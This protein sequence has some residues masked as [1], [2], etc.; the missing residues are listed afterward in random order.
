VI[1]S[2]KDHVIDSDAL[3]IVAREDTKEFD[4]SIA[5]VAEGAG[6]RIIPV[7]ERESLDLISS[8][9]YAPVLKDVPIALSARRIAD[10][11]KFGPSRIRAP[12]EAQHRLSASNG[13]TR[14]RDE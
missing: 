5:G 8:L 12:K 4:K 14:E 2:I 9:G 6:V 1:Q 7:T 10:A 11:V 3:I 13:E